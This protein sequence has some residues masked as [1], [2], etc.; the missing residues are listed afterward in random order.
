MLRLTE[1]CS[2]EIDAQLQALLK[3]LLSDSVFILVEM[4]CYS[5]HNSS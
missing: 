1:F 3:L 5:S 4:I 2:K